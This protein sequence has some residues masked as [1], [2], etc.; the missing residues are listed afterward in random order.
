M[1]DT[2]KEQ[3]KPR[4]VKGNEKAISLYPLSFEEALCALLLIPRPS[5]REEGEEERAETP[6]MGKENQ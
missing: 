2:E 6:G 1:S 4:G 3:D 5:K